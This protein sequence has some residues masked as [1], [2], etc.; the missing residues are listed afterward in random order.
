MKEKGKMPGTGITNERFARKLKSI[1]KKKGITI[2]ELAR[3]L[4]E[5]LPYL[6]EV[7]KGR[8]SIQLC[9]LIKFAKVLHVPL[10]EF[11]DCIRKENSSDEQ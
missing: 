10:L 11:S 4:D 7:I 2:Y 8:R 6:L 3:K 9:T 5:P 1:M